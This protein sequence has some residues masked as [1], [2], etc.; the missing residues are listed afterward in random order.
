MCT[1]NSFRRRIP[2]PL[3][4]SRSITKYRKFSSSCNSVERNASRMS[5]SG[6]TG[7]SL[8]TISTS[9]LN[10]SKTSTDLGWSCSI[11]SRRLRR[12]GRVTKILRVFWW[13]SL[14]VSAKT[15]INQL[16]WSC[17]YAVEDSRLASP[18]TLRLLLGDY[19]KA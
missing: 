19:P 9:R 18:P 1:D 5:S 14:G 16:Q 17:G 11:L 12:R 4:Y 8:P 10:I 6:R 13:G 15:T 3:K 2:S 7:S